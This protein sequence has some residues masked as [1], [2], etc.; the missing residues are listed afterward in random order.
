MDDTAATVN[1]QPIWIRQVCRITEYIPIQIDNPRREAH[2]PFFVPPHYPQARIPVS[3]SRKAD[4]EHILQRIRGQVPPDGGVVV[5]HQV[6]M[7]ACL[8]IAVLAREPHGLSYGSDSLFRFPE[9]TLHPLPDNPPALIGHDPGRV[10]VIAV[11]VEDLVRVGTPPH[12]GKKQ[13]H[14]CQETS[15]ARLPPPPLPRAG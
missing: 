7:E 11:H 12:D 14:R 10:Q 6:V 2:G 3:A 5:P 8:L 1:R 13:D 4:E 15:A 9:R